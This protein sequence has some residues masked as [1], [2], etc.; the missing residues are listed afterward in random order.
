MHQL[1]IIEALGSE[2]SGGRE[3][4]GGSERGGG[5]SAHRGD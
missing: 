1:K 2:R 4:G 3:Q 5:S